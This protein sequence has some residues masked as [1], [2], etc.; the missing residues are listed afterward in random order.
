M[1]CQGSPSLCDLP[2]S[3][4]SVSANKLCLACKRICETYF[5]ANMQ[6]LNDASP[7]KS[8][9]DTSKEADEEMP[10]A[11]R[12]VSSEAEEGEEMVN[13]R[14]KVHVTKSRLCEFNVFMM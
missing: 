2:P 3:A 11:S 14:K 4:D 5:D 10:V 12:H 6:V 1:L 8:T 7:C 13:C 9:Q